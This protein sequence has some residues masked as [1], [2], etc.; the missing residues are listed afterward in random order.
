MSIELNKKTGINLKKGSSI[1]L[2]K[3]GRKLEQVCFGINWGAIQHE[4]KL[5]FGLFTD[6]RQESVDL[7]G[8]VVMLDDKG[9]DI[10]L[11]YYRKL[12]SSDGSVRH[13]GDDLVGDTQDD[14]RDNEIIEVDLRRVSLNVHQIVFFLNSY[15][16]QDF[17]SIPYSRVRIFEGNRNNMLSVFAT[18][19]LSAEASF[20]GKVSMVLGR[21][22]RQDGNWV[23]SAV[24][25][26]IDARKIDD[27]ITDIRKRFA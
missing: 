1:S 17:A 12:R 8:S 3:A 6:R 2:E 27:T 15:K 16:G 10:D 11:V 18:F 21:L 24:G 13:S 22:T 26:A 14:D 20:A 5:F 4:E 23:F 9:Q 7:D 25:E 19:D